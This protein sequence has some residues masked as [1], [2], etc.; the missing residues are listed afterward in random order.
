MFLGSNAAALK[1]FRDLLSTDNTTDTLA[2][3]PLPEIPCGVKDD[4]YQERGKC[5]VC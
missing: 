2:S 1:P 5:F 4:C 3:A